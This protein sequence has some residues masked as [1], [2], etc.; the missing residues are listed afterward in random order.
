MAEQTTNNKMKTPY[1]L[2][3]AACLFAAAAQIHADDKSKVTPAQSKDKPLDQKGHDEKVQREKETKQRVERENKV[4]REQDSI[5]E[6]ARTGGYES[7]Y[8]KAVEKHAGPRTQEAVRKSKPRAGAGHPG[9]H[10]QPGL[11]G[12]EGSR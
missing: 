10:I 4:Q 12:R 3:V 5:R 2:I 1:L 6:K 7:N 11:N 9:D 8:D